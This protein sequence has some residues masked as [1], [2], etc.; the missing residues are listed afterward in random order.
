MTWLSSSCVSGFFMVF[1]VR[2]FLSVAIFAVE[3]LRFFVSDFS[4]IS[5]VIRRYA[6]GF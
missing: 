1:H 2:T 6:V 3:N 5:L 4:V